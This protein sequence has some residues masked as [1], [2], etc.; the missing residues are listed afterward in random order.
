M[1]ITLGKFALR[2]KY[3]KLFLLLFFLF[4]SCDN[5][6]LKKLRFQDG[7]VNFI[8]ARQFF[9]EKNYKKALFYINKTKVNSDIALLLKARLLYENNKYKKALIILQKINHPLIKEFRNLYIIQNLFQLNKYSAVITNGN[10]FLESDF[11]PVLKLKVLYFISFSFYNLNDENK[12]IEYG[13]KYLDNYTRIAPHIYWTVD[14]F[15]INEKNKK[16]LLTTLIKELVNKNKI[17]ILCNAVYKIYR[18]K[19]LTEKFKRKITRLIS[20]KRKMIASFITDK[21]SLYEFG[22]RFYISG[23]KDTA[24]VLFKKFI[25][26]SEKKEKRWISFVYL[27]NTI[28]EKKDYKNYLQ[29]FK[30]ES[31]KNIIARYYYARFFYLKNEYHTGLKI[32]KEIIKSK[33]KGKDEREAIINSYLLLTKIYEKNKKEGKAFNILKE[34]YLRFPFSRDLSDTLYKSS[35]KVFIK[36]D[37]V[38]A[39]RYFKYLLNNKYYWREANFFTG[40][41]YKIKGENKKAR[42][43]FIKA[44]EKPFLDFFFVCALKELKLNTPPDGIITKKHG[45]IIKK[46]ISGCENEKLYNDIL[47]KKM[48]ILM[49]NGFTLEGKIYLKEIF[50]KYKKK[51]KDKIYF[52]L[53]YW[54]NK[55]RLISYVLNYRMRL[56]YKEGL[57]DQLFVM[58]KEDLKYFYPLHFSEFIEPMAKEYNIEKALLY[59]LMRAESK[60]ELE[61]TSPA[62]AMGLM[63]IIPS[64]ADL[65]IKKSGINTEGET[66]YHPE[67]NIKLGTWYL[68]QLL[69]K[70]N[71]N[72]VYAVAA[73]NGGA[74]NIDKWIQEYKPEKQMVEAFIELMRFQETRMY[75]R[76]ILIGLFFYRK[77]TK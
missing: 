31:K 33:F 77:L 66:Y 26:I 25:G 67:L 48:E 36:K 3:F 41:I 58:D 56:L 29:Q 74:R 57:L 60:F 49:K 40:K 13:L 59:A 53:I 45:K 32:L 16:S 71:N 54:F 11:H 28:K 34:G 63:Q 20:R 70:Y 76:K 73:Y 55:N 14:K 22:Y 42:G 52:Y 12:F 62:Q 30:K 39:E 5:S 68:K 35:L 51:Y 27:L 75:T 23:Y 19:F 50:K 69:N 64:T 46:I 61:A 18:S 43:Y 9:I 7:D 8:L 1:S 37:F 4:P 65:I 21:D 47:F 10:K 6:Y 17:S 72:Y 15:F 24:E 38:K 44:L 2:N